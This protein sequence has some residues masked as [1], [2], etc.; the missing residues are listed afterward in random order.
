VGSLDYVSH[1]T[2]ISSDLS[3][4]CTDFAGERM[5]REKE[6]TKFSALEEDSPPCSVIEPEFAY[7]FGWQSG[8]QGEVYARSIIYVPSSGDDEYSIINACEGSN[9]RILSADREVSS[10][11]TNLLLDSDKGV[12][13]LGELFELIEKK[14]VCVS[15][16]LE[17]DYYETDF[18]WNQDSIYR[19]FEEARSDFFCD[20]P[21]CSSLQINCQT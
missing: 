8:Q 9:Y 11:A 5:F 15:A 4:V 1:W 10:S 18:W 16:K 7:G 19:E 17:G 14:D 2:E 13:S 6:D 12:S 20:L 3:P 21:L